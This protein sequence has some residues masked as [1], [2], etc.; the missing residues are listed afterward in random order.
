M[1]KI[2][3]PVF[4]SVMLYQVN[5]CLGTNGQK[6]EPPPTPTITQTDTIIGPPPDT[7]TF[8][9][10]IIDEDGTWYEFKRLVN[11]LSVSDSA[12]LRKEAYDWVRKMK[13]K[14]E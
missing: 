8:K 14:L 6:H 2:L 1:K 11:V 4:A 9:L 12:R 3:L 13:K 5:S 7:L 10:N